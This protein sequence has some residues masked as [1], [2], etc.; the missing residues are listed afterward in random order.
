[1][2]EQDLIFVCEKKKLRYRYR[3][4]VIKREKLCILQNESILIVLIIRHRR[5]ST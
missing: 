2:Q 5:R 3:I 4:C 1:M